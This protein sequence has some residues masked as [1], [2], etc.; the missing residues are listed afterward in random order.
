MPLT[1]PGIII[2]EFMSSV[3]HKISSCLKPQGLEYVA[4]PSDLNQVCSVANIARLLGH[5]Y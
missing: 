4:Q 2:G 1:G 5:M 3:N